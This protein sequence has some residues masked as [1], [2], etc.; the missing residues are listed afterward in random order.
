MTSIN[1]SAHTQRT[2]NL[3]NAAGARANSSA[4]NIASG[5]RT[6]VA[7]NVS[8]ELTAKSTR[9]SLSA[10]SIGA[11]NALGFLGTAQGYLTQVSAILDAMKSLTT[12]GNSGVAS[13]TW[14]ANAVT[15]FTSLVAQLTSIDT[16][17]SFN[18]A[19][20]FGGAAVIAQVG[21]FSTETFTTS[22]MA[23]VDA[24]TLTIVVD[25][26]HALDTQPHAAALGALV[27]AAIATIS[28]QSANVAIDVDALNQRLAVNS[29]Y[30]ESL[31]TQISDL[32][33]AD[34][35]LEMAN[36]TQHNV[37]EQAAQ[38]MLAQDFHNQRNILTIMR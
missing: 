32:T 7:V 15:Q 21:A 14:R 1:L 10:A 25:A 37:L 12:T 23:H 19:T 29:A 11:S 3:G 26:T 13:A 28:T 18:G 22:S 16:N 20:L 8:D 36:Y 38:A 5:E 31:G 30:D 2:L 6:K 4:T 27:D 33:E 35:S 17:A 9:S 34:P 24:A